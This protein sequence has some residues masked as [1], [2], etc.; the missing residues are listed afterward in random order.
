LVLKTELEPEDI[1]LIA[2]RV[3]DLL[4]PM[5]SYNGR[6]AEKEL[7]TTDEL[8]EYLS[9]KE[10]WVYDRV[11]S[12]GIPFLKA[13]KYLR[14]RKSEIDRWMERGNTTRPRKRPNPVRRLLEPTPPKPRRINP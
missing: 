2:Q 11:H 8:A 6:H 1:Q 3:A 9:V 14:F 12:K 10:Q 5:L 13:G 4:E 7:L